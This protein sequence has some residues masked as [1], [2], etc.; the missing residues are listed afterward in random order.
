MSI[1]TCSYCQL[2][3]H[4]HVKRYAKY[5]VFLHFKVYSNCGLVV[6]LKDVSTVSRERGRERDA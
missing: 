4:L 3:L 5:L 1:A 6:T 2:S